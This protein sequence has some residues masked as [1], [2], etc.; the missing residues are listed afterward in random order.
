MQPWRFVTCG[1]ASSCCICLVDSYLT[2]DTCLLPDFSEAFWPIHFD[3]QREASFLPREIAAFGQVGAL[4][5]SSALKGCDHTDIQGKR[6][7]ARQDP[8]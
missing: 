8:Q 5:P 6:Q 1:T 2:T 4:T 7:A 3:S